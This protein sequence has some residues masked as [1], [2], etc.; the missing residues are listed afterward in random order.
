MQK[1]FRNFTLITLGCLIIV[2]LLLGAIYR[3][4]FNAEL[5][6][7]AQR[8]SM[9]LTRVFDMAIKENP[10]VSSYLAKATR[11]ELLHSSDASLLDRLMHQYMAGPDVL[12]INVYNRQGIVVYST[13]MS[14]LGSDHSSS[15]AL[16]S[17]LTGQPTSAL[18]VLDHFYAMNGT[19]S[20][21]DAVYSYF[22]I[23]WSGDGGVDIVIQIYR[24]VS[25]RI[26]S[27]EKLL[28]RNFAYI[29]LVLLCL[30]V[31]LFLMIKAADKRTRILERDIASQQQE[32]ERLITRDTLTALPSRV[33]FLDR[34]EDA[35]RR[36]RQQEKLLAVV[37]LDLNRFKYI[38]DRFGYTSGNEL[39]VQIAE[40]LKSCVR[41]HDTVARLGGGNYALVLEDISAVDE[42]SEATNHILDILSEAFSIRG[43]DIFITFSIG[44]AIYPFDDDQAETLMQKADTAVYQAKEAGRNTYRFYNS[45]KRDKAVTRFSMEN[46]LRHALENNEFLIYY[47]PIVQFATGTITGVEALL[48]WH[49]PSQGII[50]PLEFISVLEDSGLIIPVG[51]WVLET[52]CRQGKAWQQQGF[53]DLKININISARQFKD[54]N[55]L[56][57]VSDALGI[58]KLPPHL[59]N[60][61]ITE[62][63]LIENRERVIEMLDL[64]NEKGVS[65]S[66]DDFGTGYSSMYY[67]KN[68]PIETIKID[69]SFVRGIPHDMDDVAIIHAI[70]YLSKNLRLNVI[71]E[72]VETM[73][74]LQFL[75]KLNVFAIQG[76]LISRPVPA[77][78]L[79]PL[80]RQHDPTQFRL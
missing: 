70:D 78:E 26:N 73:E 76:Y 66:V 44:I 39:L 34:L 54:G 65:M 28:N 15:L 57:S 23:D 7:A 75:Q 22:P 1:Y 62:S 2:L 30:F 18:E 9:A 52:A 14:R 77:L 59:L 58:S 38:N 36:T 68:M 20:R 24:D 80:F 41:D 45:K 53:G 35:M 60:L 3:Y 13:D 72:G 19:T 55:L 17:A 31:A 32:I 25:G 43:Q 33:L 16:R 11:K 51:Q 42:V 5:V 64:L 37:S 69:K 50:P 12:Q 74:Q 48:R 4:T 79:E 61:E 6:E 71:A 63:L 40:R 67:L 29:V 56:R 10:Q 21:Y 46:A 27:V 8:E 49:S 47:Q